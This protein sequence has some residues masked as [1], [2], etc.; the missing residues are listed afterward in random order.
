VKGTC[1][2]TV[3]AVA[4]AYPLIPR[5]RILRDL[6]RKSPGDEGKWF[7]AAKELGLYDLA[8]ERVRDS[9]RRSED[10]GARRPRSLRTG[11]GIR[12]G[13]PVAALRSV[14]LGYGCEIAA[15]DV[16]TAYHAARKA[17]EL[18]GQVT[19]IRIVIRARLAMARP[20]SFVRQVLG[21]EPEL[22]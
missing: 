7:A 21:R 9:P 3:R 16:W 18:L 10:A 4:Q 22:N 6:L 13:A 14:T 17:A 12:A 15:L 1:L 11:S 19:E 5:E 2:A 20:D 8:V